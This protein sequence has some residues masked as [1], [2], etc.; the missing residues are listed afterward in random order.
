M[1]FSLSGVLSW[2][3][4]L[5]NP[6]SSQSCRFEHWL[7]ACMTP[8]KTKQHSSHPCRKKTSF[9]MQKL[10]CWTLF[11]PV[12]TRAFHDIQTKP[13]ALIFFAPCASSDKVRKPNPRGV[14]YRYAK[15]LTLED[16]G[17]G[18]WW[19]SFVGGAVTD[20]SFLLY[21]NK[22]NINLNYPSPTDLQIIKKGVAFWH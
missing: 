5:P 15:S 8:K 11:L 20:P 17:E 12:A 3:T 18:C 1:S 7:E 21:I 13:W 6:R 9:S 19:M 2:A 22:I 14:A 16:S 4:G 10:K